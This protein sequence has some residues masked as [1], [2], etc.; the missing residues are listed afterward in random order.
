MK[1]VNL[2][3]FD[4]VNKAD[5]KQ[6]VGNYEATDLLNVRLR[7]NLLGIREG[8]EAVGSGWS[9]TDPTRVLWNV[10]ENLIGVRGNDI[11]KLV[12]GTWSATGISG[13]SGY[14]GSGNPVFLEFPAPAT[15]SSTTG[16]MTDVFT[17]AYG[18]SDS[19][20]SFTE[21][22]YVG[23]YLKITSGNGINQIRLITINTATDIGVSEAFTRMPAINDTYSILAKTATGNYYFCSGDTPKKNLDITGTTWSEMS[24][25]PKM[26]QVI[27]YRNRAVGFFEGGSTLYISSYLNAEDFPYEI[28]VGEG[29][30]SYITGVYSFGNQL[31]IHKGTYGGVWIA[32]FD[33]PTQAAAQLV[34]RAVMWGALSYESDGET[35]QT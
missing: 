16:T 2:M 32:E 26:K 5:P 23:Y 4:G 11:K 29:D 31:V 17:N 21:N 6:L 1:T 25:T 8:S 30:N 33:D 24:S 7:K 15:S 13:S 27:A 19:S 34:Q 35:S 18:I 9:G 12:S 20:K 3:G 28:E 22:Q 10:R 14:S